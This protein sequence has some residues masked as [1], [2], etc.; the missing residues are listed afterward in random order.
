MVT[1]SDFATW[2]STWDLI[3]DGTPFLTEYTCSRLLPVRQAGRLCM[4]KLAGADEEV[5]GGL[6]MA[7][8][9]GLGAAEVL[10]LDG[11]A[12]LLERAMPT[13]TLPDLSRSGEDQRA[14]E[15][16]C[17][18]LA[19][20]HTP[21]AQAPPDQLPPLELWFRDLA[22]AASVDSRLTRGW[23]IAKDLLRTQQDVVVLHGDMHHENVLWFGS[24]KWLAIDPKGLVGERAYDYANIFRNP[25]QRT[26][27]SPG[28]LEARLGQVATTAGLNP[29]RQLR[30]NA[31]HAALSAAWSLQDGRSPAWSLAVLDAMLSRI[32]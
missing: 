15:V 23:V 31:A 30:W 13:P 21:R 19:E 16:L 3:P 18:V 7:W 8:W 29:E 6:L 11:P 10:A 24:R 9:S 4:L 27:L 5:R 20:L 14:I 25:D 22:G 2:L 17:D 26:A 28:R 1:V 12:L 32:P